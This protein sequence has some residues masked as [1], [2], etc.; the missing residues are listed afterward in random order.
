MSLRLLSVGFL[1]PHVLPV[2]FFY[3]FGCFG[4]CLQFPAVTDARGLC[5][6]IRVSAVSGY[7]CDGGVHCREGSWKPGPFVGECQQKVSGR[8]RFTYG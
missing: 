4:L 7:V 1:L 6:N 2:S 8:S 3:P 5:V